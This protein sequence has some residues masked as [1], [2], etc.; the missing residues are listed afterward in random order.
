MA[1]K[2]NKKPSIVAKT[3]DGSPVVEVFG[4]KLEGDKLVMDC[5]ALGSM[6]MDVVI[7]AEDI[8]AGWPVVKENRS[9]IMSFGKKIPKA[10]RNWK[11][12]QAKVTPRND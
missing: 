7:S 9:T 3:E 2:P 8:A 5:K 6:R 11:K 1:G 4:M 10:I 12:E